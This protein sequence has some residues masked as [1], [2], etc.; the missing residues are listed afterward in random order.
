[1]PGHP[2]RTLLAFAMGCA[3]ALAWACSA[4]DGNLP[5]DESAAGQAPPAGPG[6]GQGDCSGC[7]TCL[8][9]C[10]CATNGD[11]VCTAVCSGSG[12]TGAAAGV[13]GSGGTGPAGWGGTG[14]SG[15]GGSAGSGVGGSG[16]GGGAGGAGGAGGS[17]GG[18]GPAGSG[19]AGGSTAGTGGTPSVCGD[20]VCDALTED[21]IF[22]PWDCTCGT[23][24][25]GGSAG[26]GGSGGGA[27][28]PV[29]Q[30][31]IDRAAAGVGFSY[32][33][34]HGRFLPEGPSSTNAGSCDGSCPSCTHS[35]SYGGDCSGFVA[36]VWVVPSS[37]DDMSVDSHPYSTADF[38][39]D[40]SQW[41]TVAH[42]D[43]QIA[44]AMVYRS[45]GAGHIFIYEYGD[46]WGSMY[47]YECKGCSYGCTAGMRTASSAYHA[48]RRAGY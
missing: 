15:V 27:V 6:C 46:P 48:I 39:E 44:D 20:G 13:G 25:A 33:W 12:G 26:S 28:D 4:A 45:G 41:T 43:M 14:G 23:G 31:A 35:G 37:N 8:E 30:A 7:A 32:W 9:A 11:P 2:D 21:C 47:A 5:P 1:M 42:D 16:V 34:G 29:H 17:T 3:A 10:S 40:T 24:G 19:G 22:C 36:K 38:V 18:T